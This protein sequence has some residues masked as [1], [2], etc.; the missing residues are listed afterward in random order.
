[1]KAMDKNVMLNRNKVLNK[2]YE[3]GIIFITKILC[4]NPRIIYLSS[5]LPCSQVPQFP[6]QYNVDILCNFH[7]LLFVAGA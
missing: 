4:F 7:T 3:F 6:C 2:I 5:I 1:M